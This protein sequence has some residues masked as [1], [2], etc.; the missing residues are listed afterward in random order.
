M[1]HGPSENI[2]P[3]AQL[4]QS[5][6]DQLCK[7]ENLLRESFVTEIQLLRE[8]GLDR[9]YRWENGCSLLYFMI[10]HDLEIGVPFLLKWGTS[11]NNVDGRGTSALDLADVMHLQATEELLMEVFKGKHNG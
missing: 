11:V 8:M 3:W 1:L 7:P 9:N 6:A 2:A 4:A 5:V 10:K